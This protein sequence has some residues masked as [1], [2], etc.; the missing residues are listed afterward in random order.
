MLLP[1]TR[2]IEICQ[3]I[4]DYRQI[5]PFGYSGKISSVLGLRKNPFLR[6]P[7]FSFPK[8]AVGLTP[9]QIRRILPYLAVHFC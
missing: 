3:G 1:E 7:W 9:E 4:A 6:W 2:K 5:S 8:A